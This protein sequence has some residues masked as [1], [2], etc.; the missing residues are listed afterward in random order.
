M[1]RKY[2]PSPDLVL[3]YKPF[4]IEEELIYEE[5]PV[6]ILNY[7]EQVLHTKTILIVKVLWHTHGVEEASWEV[8]QDIRNRYPNLFEEHVRI[9]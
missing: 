2:I 5:K 4:G 8:E 7:K 6:Q 9:L 1:L 3:E